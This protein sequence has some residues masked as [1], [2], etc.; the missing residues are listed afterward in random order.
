MNRLKQEITVNHVKIKNRL[1][2]PPMAT[3]KAN[4]GAVSDAILSYYDEKSKGGYIGL[5]ITEHSYV[6]RQGMAHAGQMSISRDHDIEG[7]KQLVNT[8]HR[9]GSKVIA[10]I[11]HAGSSA[12]E[13]VTGFPPISASAVLNNGA[14]GKSGILPNA[15]TQ[16]DIDEVIASFVL[17]AKRAKNAGFDGVQLHSAHGYLLN[18]FY[19]PL[20]NHRTDAYA[21]KTIEGRLRLQIGRAHV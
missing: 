17:S 7:L 10:Q 1:V 21:G 14:T 5:V 11:N 12:R 3:S 2:L 20:I 19:S 16:E 9:N 8:I 13:E 15:M 4:D 6:N 18:Q